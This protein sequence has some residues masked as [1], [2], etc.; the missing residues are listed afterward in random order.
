MRIYVSRFNSKSL[1]QQRNVV[2]YS[3]KLGVNIQWLLVCLSEKLAS[4][5]TCYPP[6][7]NLE[8]GGL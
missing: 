5:N 3:V 1:K 4:H 8:K 6:Q 2:K 7:V